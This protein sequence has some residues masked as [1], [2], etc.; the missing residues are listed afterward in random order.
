[1][2]AQ[3]RTINGLTTYPSKAN[4][5]FSELPPAVSGKRLRDILLEEH[6]LIIRECSN[7]IGS[8]ETYLRNVVRKKEDVDKLVYALGK[9]LPELTMSRV[10]VT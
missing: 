7:K 2:L 3:L 10:A 8:T 5:L 9:I 1:M 4:F 6:G